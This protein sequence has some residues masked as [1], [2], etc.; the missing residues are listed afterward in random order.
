LPFFNF[1]LTRLKHPKDILWRRHTPPDQHY[2]VTALSTALLHPEPT[3]WGVP[4]PKDAV[5]HS[6]LW[7][8]NS[9][10][11]TPFPVNGAGGSFP[12]LTP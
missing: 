12:L 7:A 1:W 2:G 10:K 11:A 9:Q 5:Y 6:Q 3:Y 8:Y 4:F